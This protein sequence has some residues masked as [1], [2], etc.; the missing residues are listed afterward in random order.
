MTDRYQKK[1]SIFPDT[2]PVVI[3]WVGELWVRL[4]GE[5]RLD[6]TR[7]NKDSRMV[8]V[9]TLEHSQVREIGAEWL[10]YNTWQ[11]L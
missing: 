3:F 8:Y 4:V 6:L 7:Y 10:C 2:D 11:E 1:T 9:D 5:K